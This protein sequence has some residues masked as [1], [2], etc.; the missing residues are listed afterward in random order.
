MQRQR[1]SAWPIQYVGGAMINSSSAGRA[2]TVT[3]HI[4]YHLNSVS[5]GCVGKRLVWP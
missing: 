5:W 4:F 2:V 3:T 1:S